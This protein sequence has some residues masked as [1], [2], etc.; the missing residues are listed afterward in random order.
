VHGRGMADC[1]VGERRNRFTHRLSER[2]QTGFPKFGH[3]DTW[4]IDELQ[5]LVERNHGVHLYPGWTNKADF[6]D[7]TE[8]S[9]TV[10]L[11]S[12]ALAQA[13]SFISLPRAWA[14]RRLCC[15]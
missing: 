14:H 7:T 11:H 12:A 15:R 2:R 9:G 4:L 6:C 10:P 13:M 8:R 5:L 1:L 3:Y